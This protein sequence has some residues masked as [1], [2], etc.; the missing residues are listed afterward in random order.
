M[1]IADKIKTLNESIKTF[2]G[3]FSI[4]NKRISAIFS[5][6]LFLLCLH[7]FY[8]YV[9]VYKYIHKRPCSIHI[10]AQTSRASVALN[11]YENSMNFFTPQYQRTLEGKGY[12]GLEFPI[13][14][15]MGAICYKLFGF[16]EMY[17]RVIS[18]V[19]TSI[20][21]LFFFLLS[22]TFTKSNLVSLCIVGAVI[23]SPVFLFYTPNFMPDPPSVAFILTGWYFLFRYFSTQK[24][25]YLNLTVIF[26]TLGMLLKVTGGICFAVLFV[27][28]ILDKL[29][30]FRNKE[31][32]ALFPEKKRLI[33]KSCV[34]L[35][36]VIS[37][38][39]YSTWFPAT[40]GGSTFL[41]NRNSYESWADTLDVLDWIKKLWLDHYYPYE[42][43]V[44]LIAVAA[45]VIIFCWKAN[46]LLLTITVLYFLGSLCYF[47]LFLR[48][49]KHHD[50]YIITMLPTF[51]F[52]F[53]CFADII[54]KTAEKYFYP[55]QLVLLVVFFFNFKESFMK[56]RQSYCTRYSTDIYYWTGDFRAYEDL[57]PKLRKLGIKREDRVI[58][59]F[60]AT[61]CA[62]IYLM[63][64]LGIVFSSD[65]SKS[66]VDAWMNYPTVK[67]MVLNDSA[68]FRRQYNYDL[69]DKVIAT[70]RGLMIYRLK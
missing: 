59:G 4:G 3:K 14:Y 37:W 63:N 36:V 28:L 5:I 16:D 23:C 48:Q 66:E 55:L 70:H 51:F 45:L 40:H 69:S 38:Y 43:Y 46:R 34:G 31:R 65:N 49:F 12:T 42:G 58:S 22:R 9:G 54:R 19:I 27:L 13:I 30:F 44:L 32:E 61:D 11:Y 57:E 33:I 7:F 53:L 20:G 15:Y 24:S 67:Y 18:L 64:Q 56:S 1:G 25:P 68:T 62:S 41:L 35:A 29:K 50:Y 10:S 47:Y 6:V 17:L 8:S 21:L 26:F 39:K 52:M 60:D 2:A